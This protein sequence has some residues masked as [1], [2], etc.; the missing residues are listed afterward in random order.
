MRCA[1]CITS[2][3]STHTKVIYYHGVC[4]YAYFM[5]ILLYQLEITI[6][7]EDDNWPVLDQS[8]YSYTITNDT[9]VGALFGNV[10]ATDDDFLEEHRRLT[11]WTD[12]RS[13]FHS[14]I[15]SFVHSFI[16][17]FVQSVGRSVGRSVILS[18]IHKFVHLFIRAFIH[19]SI[20][21][22]IQFIKLIQIYVPDG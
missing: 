19:P 4:S 7:E 17:S 8:A 1:I 3:C 14:F 20:R 15:R 11:Y 9:T 22:T 21:L 2:I 18:C 13:V 6:H 16:H 5:Y 12:S 10:D